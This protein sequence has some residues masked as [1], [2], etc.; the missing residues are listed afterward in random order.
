MKIKRLNESD[1]YKPVLDEKR[2]YHY[3]SSSYITEF[4]TENSSMTQNNAC[5]YV[6]KYGIC[7]GDEP[8]AF[9]DDDILK[10]PNSYNPEQV[11]WVS[12]FFE[13]HPFLQNKMAVVFDD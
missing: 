3:V 12:A 11:K 8:V 2:L 4:I 5:V 10:H 1:S 9:W 13:A 6:R 7:D